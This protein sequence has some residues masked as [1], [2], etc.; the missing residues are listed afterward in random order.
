MSGGTSVVQYIHVHRIHLLP[1]DLRSL[2]SDRDGAPLGKVSPIYQLSRSIL[3]FVV[4]LVQV[5][6]ATID[7]MTFT[8]WPCGC[9]WSSKAVFDRGSMD[10]SKRHDERWSPFDLINEKETRILGA[11]RL[12]HADRLNYTV[13][14][15]P[16]FL[17]V[18]FSQVVAL[19]PPANQ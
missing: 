1:E 17:W 4:N 13:L 8:P 2:Q 14:L 10:D 16:V 3:S 15:S 18:D 11:L 5:E 12:P 6:A 9:F 7:N 19:M